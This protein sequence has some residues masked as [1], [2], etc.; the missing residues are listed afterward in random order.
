[1][2]VEPG[3]NFG[4][5]FLRFPKISFGKLIYPVLP[6]NEADGICFEGVSRNLFYRHLKL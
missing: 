3:L 5:V 6:E 1:M 2:P 4:V